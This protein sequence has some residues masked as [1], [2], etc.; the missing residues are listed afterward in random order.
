MIVPTLR[1]V[2]A[3]LTLRVLFSTQS[4]AGCMPTRSVGTIKRREPL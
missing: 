4:V 1:V 3:L 2:T